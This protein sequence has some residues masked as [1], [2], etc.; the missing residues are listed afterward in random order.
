MVTFHR[1]ERAASLPARL[2]RSWMLIT[3]AADEE[4]LAAALESEADSILIDL[5]DG[6]PSDQKTEA[7]ERVMHWLNNGVEAWVR[8]N[9]FGTEEWHKDVEELP[10]AKGLRGVMLAEVED[11]AMVTR[12]AMMLPPG[13]PIIA[14]IE[15]AIGIVNAVDIARAPGVFRLAFGIGDF[16]KDTG[17]AADAL[18]LAYVRSQLVLASRVGELP[19]PIDGP[20]VGKHGVDLMKDCSITSAA[21]MTGKLTLDPAQVDTINISLAPS[22]DEIQWARDLL[23]KQD[24]DA[25]PKDG[26]YLPRLARA[27]KVSQLAKTYGLWRS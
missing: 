12:T 26:S 21:G 18:S 1:N 4:R 8:I 20:S 17:M 7:R 22:E 3:A 14:L 10:K 24:G 11:A 2:S 23:Q 25:M 15:S 16:R 19:G 27:K 6:T 5:E 13:T 9:K